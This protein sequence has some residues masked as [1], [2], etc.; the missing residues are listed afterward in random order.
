MPSVLTNPQDAHFWAF[1]ALLVLLAVLWRAKAHTMLGKALDTSGDTV[2]AQLAEAARLRQE[3]QDL[4]A[5]IQT[6][7]AE[8]ERAAA[9]LM[10]AAQADAERLRKESA[11]R[12]EEDIRRRGV[13]AE[14]K[15]A[16]AEAQAANEVK[17][18]AA[19]MAAQAAEAVLA[20]R[21]AN[22]TSDPLID[23]GLSQLGA[24]FS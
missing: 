18:A 11:A 17:A 24:R 14:R 9:E 15:I 1:I 22:A 4:L 20:G 6:Q 19:E 2:K 7:R 23:Q 5:Q 8:T 21:L 12:L 16:L 3:A 10:A 13:L